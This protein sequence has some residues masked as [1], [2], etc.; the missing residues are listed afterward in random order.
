[1]LPTVLLLASAVVV[2]AVVY[3]GRREM[4]FQRTRLSVDDAAARLAHPQG[5]GAILASL[6]R[7]QRD[8]AAFVQPSVVHIEC[9]RG[10]QTAPT[11]STGSGWIWDD[12]GHI[13]TVWHVVRDADE[14]EVQLHDG[15]RR[16]GY[17]SAYDPMTDIAVVTIDPARTIPATRGEVDSIRQGDL[18]FAFGS[19]LDF[20]F[21]VTGGVVSGLGRD[22]GGAAGTHAHSYENFI[23]IDAPINP[24]S[25]GGPVTDHLGQVIGMSTAIAADPL[26]SRGEDRFT[27]VALAIPLDMI[28]SIV[29]QLLADG[30]VHRGYLGVA[31]LDTDRP[32]RAMVRLSGLIGRQNE[33]GAL[34]TSVDPN[35]GLAKA[36]L[37]PGDILWQI[38]DQRVRADTV[39]EL[40]EASDGDVEVRASHILEDEARILTCPAAPG[41]IVTVS[42]DTPLYELLASSGA[43]AAGVLI[44]TPTPDGPA[45]KAGLHRGDVIVSIN[46]RQTRSVDQLRAIISACSPGTQIEV[47]V[48]RP[49]AAWTGGRFL[50]VDA[51]LADR[52]PR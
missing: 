26:D 40:L 51:T 16:T 4:E 39:A 32:T 22:V 47:R 25:S 10:T 1:L 11:L 44:S 50:N 24:G 23:Q 37:R 13:V 34:V 17:L 28:N 41:D 19:P 46:D 30:S 15:A 27:G 6:S 42:L 29:P 20:R 14:I 7:A 33:N 18:V 9:Q 43:P 12:T 31:I 3:W 52:G 49:D 36:G 35:S 5:D 38:G 21:S 45:D 8:L 2:I 48:W